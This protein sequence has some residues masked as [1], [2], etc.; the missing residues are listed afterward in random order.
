[1]LLISTKLFKQYCSNFFDLGTYLDLFEQTEMVVTYFT[2]EI[3]Y[4]L[5]PFKDRT[6]QE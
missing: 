1:M 6:G 5:N 3:N 4:Y 2:G